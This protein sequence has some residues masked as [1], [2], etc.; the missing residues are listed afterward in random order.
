MTTARSRTTVDKDRTAWERTIAEAVGSLSGRMDS[1]IRASE[2]RLRKEDAYEV[3]FDKLEREVTDMKT[4]VNETHTAVKGF[5]GPMEVLVRWLGRVTAWGGILYI[6]V[7]TIWGL[8]GTA[9]RQKAG[10]P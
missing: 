6:V 4:I 1:L 2:D 10:L 8:F 7:S 5:K 9:I 3:R